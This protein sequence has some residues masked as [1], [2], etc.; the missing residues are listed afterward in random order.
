MCDATHTHI[1]TLTQRHAHKLKNTH[2]HTRTH[3]NTHTHTHTH[4]HTTHTS[5][6]KYLFTYVCLCV[7]V[8][9][10]V[11]MCACVCMCVCVCMRT[12]V[13]R[14]LGGRYIYSC[15]CACACVCVCMCVC[16]CVCVCA[17][18]FLCVCVCVF[19]CVCARAR[20]EACIFI[21]QI[22]RFKH[23][24]DGN[25]S[26]IVSAFYFQIFIYMYIFRCL[27]VAKDLP[28]VLAVDWG[29][30]TVRHCGTL[31]HMAAHG[32]ALQYNEARYR[33]PQHTTPH[34]NTLQHTA[35]Q[36]NTLQ[37]TATPVL[38]TCSGRVTVFWSRNLCASVLQYVAM[39][40]NVLQCA[41][42]RYIVLQSVAV[43]CSLLL[44]VC[45]SVLINNLPQ[46]FVKSH[47][48][49][50]LN[51]RLVPMTLS[52]QTATHPKSTKYRN[53]NSSVSC[54]T[55]SNRHFGLIWICTEESYLWI[56]GI[57]GLVHI[58]GKLSQQEH[59]QN[60]DLLF[61]AWRWQSWPKMF[62]VTF[63]SHNGIF[64]VI[65]DTNRFRKRVLGFFQ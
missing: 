40:Y 3:T 42:A 28:C 10:C 54:V 19:V 23:S 13:V 16:V 44:W 20:V 31:Q 4:T 63:L 41:A 24:I 21:I 11:C 2:A 7:C 64:Q 61:S 65:G 14:I 12:C 48:A 22:K 53:S 57:P 36:C 27:K 25:L 6:H 51:I 8:C 34:S 50:R 46:K 26:F 32:S 17:C 58:Q 52:T 56:W 39:R 49:S 35:T 29:F 30:H 60:P 55:N 59:S 15:A 1:H 5:A 37:H 18:V 47:V 62:D 43:C 45:C 38:C 9:V 33:T